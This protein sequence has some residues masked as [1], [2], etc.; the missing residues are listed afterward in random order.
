M[1]LRSS[2]SF[3]PRAWLWNG[4][5]R[6]GLGAALAFGL[7][8]G[9]SATPA[10][11]EQMMP[12]D[13]GDTS[14]TGCRAGSG[15][16]MSSASCIRQGTDYQPGK[17]VN[18]WPACVSDGNTY[19]PINAN[20]STVARITAFETIASLLW[21]CDKVPT[22]ADF[23]EAKVQLSI[24]NGLQSRL[25]RREDE[26]YPAFVNGMGQTLCTDPVQSVNQPDRCVGPVRMV[27]ALNAAVMAGA[28]GQEPRVQAARVEGILIWFLYTSV[29]KEAVTCGRDKLDDCDSSWAYYTGGE[30]RSSAG[31]GF[32]RYTKVADA[33]AA[34]RVYD[35]S[36]AVRCWR[37][38]DRMLPP[39]NRTLQ[40]LAYGQLDRALD[41]ALA[42]TV[43]DRLGYMKRNSGERRAADWAFVSITAAALDRAATARNTPLA[44]TLR[45]EVQKTD[46]NS[47]NI[48]DMISTLQQL[49][50][51]S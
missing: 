40:N 37:D 28:S 3:S 21:E 20:I 14:F 5:R 22:P 19:V 26:H 51:C 50:P 31:K 49:F 17:T 13:L 44:Q 25:D 4:T 6:A 47:V 18:P 24:A 27:P 8:L 41:R 1:T 34:D 30:A 29:Y 45:K 10:E 15:S 46:P 7:G 33:A 32:M 11:Q 48:D 9:C 38:V 23:A 42:A 35:A 12:P 2:S 39:G 43:I 36:L 16:V